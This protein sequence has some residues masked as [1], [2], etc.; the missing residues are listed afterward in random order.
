MIDQVN[1][2]ITNVNGKVDIVSEYSKQRIVD[3]ATE[4]NGSEYIKTES[5]EETINIVVSD[6]I[7]MNGIKDAGLIIDVVKTA[8]TKKSISEIFDEFVLTIVEV[9]PTVNRPSNGYINLF[10]DYLFALLMTD[11]TIGEVPK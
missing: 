2:A 7:G 6:L 9:I 4:I 11:K 10:L 5:I 3:F 8:K 1:K